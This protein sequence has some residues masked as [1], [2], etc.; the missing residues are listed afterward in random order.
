MANSAFNNCEPM[1]WK[2]I[3]QNVI[4]E[5]NNQHVAYKVY[6]FGTSDANQYNIV[7]NRLLLI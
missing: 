3:P 1:L 4:S 6:Y 2:K 7:C 5:K